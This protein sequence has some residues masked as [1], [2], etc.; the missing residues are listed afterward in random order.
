MALDQRYAAPGG[1]LTVTLRFPGV[2]AG[3]LNVARV[4]AAF[5]TTGVAASAA[6]GGDGGLQ[7][8]APC[9]LAHLDPERLEVDLAGGQR[10]VLRLRKGAGGG[11]GRAT[12]G[13]TS[14]R[15]RSTWRRGGAW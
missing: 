14:W 12:S 8:L 13:P 4:D 5:L 9:G 10:A 2:V 11:S 1:P 15:R 3:E 7:Y 6:G